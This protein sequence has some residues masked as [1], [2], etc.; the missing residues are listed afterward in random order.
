MIPQWHETGIDPR[1]LCSQVQIAEL[2]KRFVSYDTLRQYS[3]HSRKHR[4]WGP[5]PDPVCRISN[6]NLWLINDIEAWTS[7]KPKRILNRKLLSDWQ[8]HRSGMLKAWRTQQ[9]SIWT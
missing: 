7:N 2:V 3:C 4:Y 6:R 9:G 8:E 5:M 1:E